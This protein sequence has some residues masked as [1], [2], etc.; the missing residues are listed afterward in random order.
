MKSVLCIALIAAMATPAALAQD[1]P[2]A[3]ATHKPFDAAAWSAEFNGADKDGDGKLSREEAASANPNL[4]NHFDTIDAD[5]DGFITAEEDRA[6]LAR[7][8]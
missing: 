7:P 1:S 5:G 6:M 3:D 8:Q 4:G 2:P